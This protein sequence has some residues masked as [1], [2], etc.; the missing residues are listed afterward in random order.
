[1]LM[2]TFINAF[3]RFGADYCAYVAVVLIL[4][5]TFEVKYDKK[6][7]KEY[8]ISNAHKNQ[9]HTIQVTYTVI[10]LIKINSEKVQ[11]YYYQ[12][13]TLRVREGEWGERER[14]RER[15]TQTDRQ[16]DRQR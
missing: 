7:I 4:I 16:T 3:L 11:Y 5:K 1:M 10:L 12:E 2:I 9:I 14:D 13:Y 8:N 15:Q 6:D